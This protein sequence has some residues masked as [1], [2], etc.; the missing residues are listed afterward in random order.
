MKKM[1][2]SAAVTSA[3]TFYTLG[4]I[5]APAYAHGPQFEPPFPAPAE[6]VLPPHFPALASLRG[7][8]LSEEQ[9]DKHFKVMHAAAPKLHAQFKALRQAEQALRAQS[10]AEPAAL[11]AHADAVGRAWAGLALTRA[12]LD[13]QILA[14]LTPEQRRQW[15]QFPLPERLPQ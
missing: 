7:I 4:G 8:R 14:L 13:R 15:Q 12:E 10:Q 6:M 11:Q 2:L 9:Q 5:P 1:L 3:A